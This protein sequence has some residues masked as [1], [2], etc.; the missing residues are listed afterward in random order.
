[1]SQIDT[2]AI[3]KGSEIERFSPGIKCTLSKPRN[4]CGGSPALAGKV[5]YNCGTAEPARSPVFVTSNITEALLSGVIE[6]A[7]ESDEK[8]KDV[9]DSP[10]PNGKAGAWPT[11]S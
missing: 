7:T 9:Y 4:T 5:K 2:S 3:D 6:P 10:N 11:A 8:L 1:M